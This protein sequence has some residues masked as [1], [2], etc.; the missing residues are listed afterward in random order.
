MGKKHRGGEKE[1]KKERRLH[2]S[3]NKIVTM[4]VLEAA[5][6]VLMVPFNSRNAFREEII[7][8]NQDEKDRFLWSNTKK[9]NKDIKKIEES[10]FDDGLNLG[11]K[12]LKMMDIVNA[13]YSVTVREQLLS[14]Y[15]GNKKLVRLIKKISDV[16]SNCTL[17][18]EKELQK[19]KDNFYVLV[20]GN[21][22]WAI[23]MS[24]VSLYKEVMDNAELSTMVS[25]EIIDYSQVVTDNLCSRIIDGSQESMGEFY[26]LMFMLLSYSDNSNYG[27]RNFSAADA[28]YAKGIMARK[29]L[30]LIP[31]INN[32]HQISENDFKVLW[33]N[34]FKNSFD[35]ANIRF[36][37]VKEGLCHVL[38]RDTLN[39]YF[40]MSEENQKKYQLFKYIEDIFKDGEADSGYVSTVVKTIVSSMSYDKRSQNKLNALCAY[41]G[42][43]QCFR[44]TNY[45][46]LMSFL[47]VMAKKR[48]GKKGIRVAGSVYG[49]EIKQYVDDHIGKSGKNLN[50]VEQKELNSKIV[51]E[52]GE[53]IEANKKAYKGELANWLK[54]KESE[55][56]EHEF[57]K[58]DIED[59]EFLKSAIASISKEGK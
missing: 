45:D 15:A 30:D 39:E 55:V 1:M 27:K 41:Y 40:A 24:Y 25:F 9:S 19:Y 10:I 5:E 56:K 54:E 12:T 28:F 52:Y 20:G 31:T 14:F 44:I 18:R 8:T 37:S 11:D 50:K 23:I 47:L 48:F 59:I 38:V 6:K 33:N 16:L 32:Q 26:D 58:I 57:T 4:P 3:Q 49:R 2:N 42:I 36:G 35:N 43:D 29:A 34:N 22:R 51:N 13:C 17:N 7:G 46:N 21:T 53:N